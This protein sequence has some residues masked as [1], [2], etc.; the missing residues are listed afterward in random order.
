V[1][2]V[3]DSKSDRLKRYRPHD[4]QWLVIVHDLFTKGA[5][6]ELTPET[7]EHQYTHGFDRVFWLHPHIPRCRELRRSTT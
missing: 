1:Q 4:R 7:A 5:A 2:Q 6:A 3:L